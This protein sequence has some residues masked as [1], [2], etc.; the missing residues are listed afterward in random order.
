LAARFS[1]ARQVHVLAWP[2]PGREF[3]AEHAHPEPA[4]QTQFQALSHRTLDKRNRL[5]QRVVIGCGH[6]KIMR[7]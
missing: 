2:Q 7:K 6:A 4:E 1:R 3:R 5:R